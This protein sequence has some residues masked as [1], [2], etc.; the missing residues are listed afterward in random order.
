MRS[1]IC[2][3]LFIF[4]LGIPALLLCVN[5]PAGNVI[6]TIWTSSLSPYNI[7]GDITIPLGNSLTI[8][9]GVQVIFQGY[10]SMTVNGNLIAQ[11]GEDE[12]S[13]IIFTAS[14]GLYWR[15]ISFT[16]GADCS[17]L[18]Y[19]Q[20]VRVR[21]SIALKVV[22]TQNLTITQCDLKYNDVVSNV[23]IQAFV[24]YVKNSHNLTFTHNII[25]NNIAQYTLGA[26]T[27]SKPLL[28]LDGCDNVV[29]TNN[30]ISDNYA[31]DII[32]LFYRSCGIEQ[33]V[34]ILQNSITYNTGTNTIINAIYNCINRDQLR[35]FPR[36]I[37]IEENII[38]KNT[39][40]GYNTSCINLVGGKISLCSNTISNN[41][42]AT[43]GGGVF[44]LSEY[45]FSESDTLIVS[46]N[47]ISYNTAEYGAGVT[48]D[49]ALY[50]NNIFILENNIYQNTASA[51]GGGIYVISSAT[52][53]TINISNNQIYLNTAE[54]GGG[55][56]VKNC[57][58]T[59]CDN[60]PSLDTGQYLSY[61]I[62]AHNSA[63]LGAGVYVYESD[64]ALIN[65]VIAYNKGKDQCPGYGLFVS[66]DFSTIQDTKTVLINSILWGNDNE[67]IYGDIVGIDDIIFI[68][69]TTILG[70]LNS[71]LFSAN[72]DALAIYT[73]DPL[74][75]DPYGYDFHILNEDYDSLYIG[76]GIPYPDYI[77]VFPFDQN[78]LITTD[79][80]VLSGWEWIS[81]PILDRDF[82]SDASV[83]F[84]TITSSFSDHILHILQETSSVAY[85]NPLGWVFASNPF[86][87]KST[88][89][90]K[91]SVNKGIYHSLQ[92]QGS[93]LNPNT[94][95]TLIPGVENW[96]GYFLPETQRVLSAIDST[97]LSKISSI[98]GKNGAVYFEYEFGVP[99]ATPPFD[100]VKNQP[101]I[102]FGDMV[103]ITL[104]SNQSQFDFQ[105]SRGVITIPN[106]R[107]ETRFFNFTEKA[108]YQSLFIELDISRVPDEIGALIN[109]VC[110]GAVVYQGKVSE[111]LLY[112]DDSDF[113]EEIE[114]VFAYKNDTKTS[115]KKIDSFAVV[116]HKNQLH[117][118]KPL[119]AT[120]SIPYYHIKYT[121]NNDESPESAPAPFVQLFQNY[122]NPFNPDTKIDFYLSVEDNITL[123]VFNI[124]GQK[125]CDLHSGITPAGKHCVV[126][127]GRNS[128]GGFVSSGI[129]LYKLTT[130]YSSTQRKMLLIK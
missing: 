41:R 29:F 70:G 34:D 114:I 37:N 79:G 40:Y 62:V 1:F 7:L 93:T 54:I 27:A 104:W 19:T 25:T 120:A 50:S 71:I 118:Y 46:G 127:N 119:K 57:I 6:E 32:K 126:W 66:R 24:L 52:P 74:L 89:G 106:T 4:I 113:N 108:D 98:K 86:D 94:P 90:Y 128:T 55:I 43:K 2:V 21:D 97:T 61:N 105:W 109:G 91:I 130:S 117:E 95:V 9:P 11:G 99:V 18:E 10:Y 28:H 116:D 78:H 22:A 68:R 88:D 36:Y 123:S 69:N 53:T 35:V 77:G 60:L 38:S 26:G 15:G 84:D 39:L 73:I 82:M 72:I 65:N 125:V 92:I 129:Y 83:S 14:S 30:K 107:Q 122:P 85:Q 103:V 44:A 58:A 96:V 67:Q 100:N 31:L 64:V 59:S 8:E 16:D 80:R 47:T 33:S 23:D 5:I 17:I 48:I 124:K 115:R 111:V 76:F 63:Q 102:S 110:K 101:T 112:L 42:G 45:F 51:E 3:A 87:F 49:S 56:Y 81:F 20:I 75:A 13:K 12:N 121:D